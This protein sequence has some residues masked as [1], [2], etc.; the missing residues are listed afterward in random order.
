MKRDITTQVE[1]EHTVRNLLPNLSCLGRFSEQ[2][3]N[4][5]EVPAPVS[6]L[7]EQVILADIYPL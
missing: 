4:R 1:I 3:A 6:I 5:S 2:P 7:N